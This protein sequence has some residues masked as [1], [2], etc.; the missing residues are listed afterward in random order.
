MLAWL[1]S[2]LALLGG[3]EAGPVTEIDAPQPRIECIVQ[4][5]GDRKPHR[6]SWH[7]VCTLA[8]KHLV[9]QD[10]GRARQIAHRYGC[11]VRVVR[12]NGEDLAVHA[13]LQPRRIDVGFGQARIVRIVEIG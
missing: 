5:F 7:H 1:V 4:P 2:L 11:T 10:M 12:R 13:D 9:G 3:A 6:C 8:S